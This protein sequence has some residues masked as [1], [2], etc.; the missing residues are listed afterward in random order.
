VTSAEKVADLKTV[1]TQEYTSSSKNQIHGTPQHTKAS[2][3]NM[4]EIISEKEEPQ[5]CKN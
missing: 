4:D 3:I 2:R 1:K 5:T